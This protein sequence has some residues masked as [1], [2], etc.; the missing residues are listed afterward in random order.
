MLIIPF[1]TGS[2]RVISIPSQLM[3][4]SFSYFPYILTLLVQILRA[5][6]P[7]LVSPAAAGLPSGR[8]VGVHRR[9]HHHLVPRLGVRE[10][11]QAA[12]VVRLLRS[13]HVRPALLT[14]NSSRSMLC[15]RDPI[16]D[17]LNRVILHLRMCIRM[18]MTV[19]QN[20]TYPNSK[21]TILDKILSKMHPSNS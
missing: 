10:R 15:Y 1:E 20:M 4:R 11:F 12:R 16:Y 2:Q 5:E 19:Y 9:A 18:F 6:A 13:P 14:S 17:G 3:R 7:C 8:P 21:K